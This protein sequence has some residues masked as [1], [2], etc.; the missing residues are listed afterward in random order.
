MGCSTSKPPE[1]EVTIP[2]GSVKVENKLPATAEVND[3]KVVNDAVVK[4]G[5]EALKEAEKVQ[6][7]DADNDKLR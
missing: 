5:V 3:V 6:Q 1:I 7:K 4:E 2:D